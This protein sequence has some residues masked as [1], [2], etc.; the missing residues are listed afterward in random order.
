[1]VYYKKKI[2]LILLLFIVISGLISLSFIL[3]PI[4]VASNSSQNLSGSSFSNNP[5]QLETGVLNIDGQE[6]KIEIASTDSDQ[7][8]GLSNR[9]SLCSGCGMLFDF[10]DY[11]KLAFVMRDMRFPLDI[12]FINNNKVIN[13]AANLAPEGNKPKNIYYS[14]GKANRVLEVNSGYCEKNGIKVGDNISEPLIN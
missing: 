1:M 3:Y 6:L 4:S 11:D 8:R 2:F 13:I 14:N 12:I 10:S 7:Y 9:D 5:V